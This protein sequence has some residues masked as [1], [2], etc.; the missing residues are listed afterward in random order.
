M[1]DL[2]APDD[3]AVATIAPS[4]SRTRRILLS[5]AGAVVLQAVVRVWDQFT[6][7]EFLSRLL[8]GAI[9]AA[10]LLPILLAVGQIIE[11]R[12]GRDTT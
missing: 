8:Q 11:D 5:L 3:R 12:Q 7:S 6:V 2:Q 10:L 4:R 9:L 1:G